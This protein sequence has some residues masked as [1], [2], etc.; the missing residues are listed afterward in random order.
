MGMIQ[1]LED[2]TINTDVKH[3]LTNDYY[4]T[5]YNLIPSFSEIDGTTHDMQSISRKLNLIH[6]DSDYEDLRNNFP[7]IINIDRLP[8]NPI[9]SVVY[10]LHYSLLKNKLPLFPPS[11][12]YI[13]KNISFYKKVT[14]IMNFQSI[15][16]SIRKYGFCSENELRTTVENFS[17][18]INQ[19]LLNKSQSFKFVN[20]YKIANDVE[21]LKK[22]LQNKF[23]IL[24]GFT[25]FNDLSNLNDTIIMPNKTIDAPM[26][27]LSGVIVGYI[28]DQEV[29]IMASTFG[30]H[31]G[32]AGYI[33]IP[34]DYISKHY[35]FELYVVDIDYNR[36]MGHVNQKKTMI[37]LEEINNTSVY[38]NDMFNSLFS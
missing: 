5:K 10:M 35:T 37:E 32:N 8:F 20:T 38:K 3:K 29:F 19:N 16:N 13:Y 34:F 1:S 14:S 17:T 24:I 36:V 30:E 2:S 26:G 25:I 6:K 12:I 28:N 15:F 23:P 9:A 18:E 31:F 11:M 7:N 22:L 4:H 27:G 21:I 33:N